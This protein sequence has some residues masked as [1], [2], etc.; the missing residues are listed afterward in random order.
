MTSGDATRNVI[1]IPGIAPTASWRTIAS[2]LDACVAKTNPC[3]DI[4]SAAAGEVGTTES[5]H[6]HNAE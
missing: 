4:E 5:M 1:V 2:P 6:A 3:T